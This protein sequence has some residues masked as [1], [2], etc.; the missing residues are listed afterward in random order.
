[1]LEH[2]RSLGLS[3]AEAEH[4]LIL[5]CGDWEEVGCVFVHAWR[6]FGRWLA[7]SSCVPCTAAAAG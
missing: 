1:M 7:G 2:T 5:A 3:V 4:E 6:L